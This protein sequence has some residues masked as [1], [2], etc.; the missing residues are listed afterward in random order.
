MPTGARVISKD[1]ISKNLDSDPKLINSKGGPLYDSPITLT[2]NIKASLPE[3][4]K[5]YLRLEIDSISMVGLK[6]A[7][8]YTPQ[9]IRVA[10]KLK[11]NLAGLN[12]DGNDFFVINSGGSHSIAA[13]IVLGEQGFLLVP[14]FGKANRQDTAIFNYF[15][16]EIIQ[17]NNQNS[18][19]WA[20]IADC[21]DDEFIKSIKFD[22]LPIPKETKR[23]VEIWNGKGDKFIEISGPDC[24]SSPYVNL[25]KKEGYITAKLALNP[26]PMDR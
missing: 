9:D 5:P 1:L 6:V 19:K 7:G 15:S 22:M 4:L 10:Q 13:A 16:E 2:H 18:N 23:V 24:A 8:R 26:Y 17:L 3:H 25:T 21:H 11:I 20:L 14:F 12:L